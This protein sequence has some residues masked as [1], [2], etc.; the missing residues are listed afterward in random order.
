MPLPSGY[1]ADWA[2]CCD[3]CAAVGE[4]PLPASTDTL[5]EFL[6][7]HPAAAGTQ[8]R[9]YAAVRAAHLAARLPAPGVA[10][11]DRPLVAQRKL[12]AGRG[13]LRTVI[14]ALSTSG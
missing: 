2:L 6:E 9:R 8:R 4:D 12:T 1:R 14:S 10:A 11:A 13:Q 5:V 7:A 3:W